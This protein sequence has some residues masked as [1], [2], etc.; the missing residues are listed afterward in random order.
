MINLNNLNER[1]KLINQQLCEYYN[2]EY[3]NLIPEN[4]LQY[5]E[6]SESKNIINNLITFNDNKELL[7]IFDKFNYK[8][9]FTKLESLNNEI[10]LLTSKEIIEKFKNHEIKSLNSINIYLRK[11]LKK[12]NFN[13]LSTRNTL[14]NKKRIEVYFIK[15][16]CL[17]LTYIPKTSLNDE[18]YLDDIIYYINDSNKISIK[19][20]S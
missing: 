16:N 12:Y 1:S 17:N 9:D 6:K 8:F 3:N 15:F 5:M 7:D 2:Y 20:K 4:L 19:L 18:K 11:I 14:E 13:I 10:T